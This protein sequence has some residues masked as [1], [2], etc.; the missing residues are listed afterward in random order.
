MNKLSI[1]E[2]YL[3]YLAA[4]LLTLN[5][6]VKPLL[7]WQDEQLLY[8][9]QQEKR[10][11]KLEGL[12]QA[13][14]DL[15]AINQEVKRRLSKVDTMIPTIN[16]SEF[17]IQIQKNIAS[18]LESKKIKIDTVAW[19]N[20]PDE[21]NRFE[22]TL[23]LA[24]NGQVSDILA[25]HIALEQAYPNANITDMQLNITRHLAKSLGT[26]R[27]GIDITFLVTASKDAT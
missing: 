7:E 16:I 11:V 20:P 15:L 26:A 17:K 19:R 3:L 5:F 27:A 8:L 13:K 24:A 18:I 23:E 2:L 25:A 12:L 22:L 6:L 14:P 1:K 21:T 9:S 4:F 10:L